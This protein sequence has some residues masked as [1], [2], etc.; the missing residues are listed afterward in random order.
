MRYMGGGARHFPKRAQFTN[1][2]TGLLE[3]VGG[4]RMMKGIGDNNKTV[5]G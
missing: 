4:G 1:I 5:I 3:A 2:S